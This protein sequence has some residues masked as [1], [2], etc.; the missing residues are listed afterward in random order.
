MLKADFCLA[1]NS[2]VDKVQISN[3]S[4]TCQ[5]IFNNVDMTQ[6][7]YKVMLQTWNEEPEKRP[8]F[9]QLVAIMGDFL[10]AN[11]K[12]VGISFPVI[13]VVHSSG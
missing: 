4:L 8:S 12:Q 13:D 9:G 11:V 5:A 10:E 1:V 6:Y 3:N 2:P 7:R